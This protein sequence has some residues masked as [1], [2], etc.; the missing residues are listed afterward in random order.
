MVKL[1]HV[2]K[3]KPTQGERCQ[4]NAVRKTLDPEVNAVRVGLRQA[5]TRVEGGRSGKQL[6]VRC[7]QIGRGYRPV[8]P[9]LGARPRNTAWRGLTRVLMLSHL[10]QA[11]MSSSASEMDPTG[12]RQC[13]DPTQQTWFSRCPLRYTPCDTTQPNTT[14]KS[15][16]TTRVHPLRMHAT[17]KNVA[18]NLMIKFLSDILVATSCLGQC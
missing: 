4:V 16:I 8:A 17:F 11:S 1:E 13:H 9:R 12:I 15:R 3:R 10:C 5:E 2:R 14:H 6:A 7:S 18:D